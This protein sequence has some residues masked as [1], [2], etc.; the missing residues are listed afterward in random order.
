MHKP[1]TLKPTL[2]LSS[3]VSSFVVCACVC[4][5][6]SQSRPYSKIIAFFNPSPLSPPIPP[7][8]SLSAPLPSPHHIIPRL[9]SVHEICQQ[10][11]ILGARKAT[12]GHSSRA[13]LHC[14]SLVVPVHRLCTHRQVQC[15]R[16]DLVQGCFP[17]P[18]IASLLLSQ[19]HQ[20]II[21]DRV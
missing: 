6:V 2:Y 3:L 12:G 1:I 11:G 15:V 16:V 17:H 21:N 9:A 19:F 18:H 8:S 13:L 7:L 14:D 10:D 5:F 4:A 20:S